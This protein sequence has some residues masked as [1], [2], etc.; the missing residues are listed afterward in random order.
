MYQELIEA[1][2]RG[3][4][5]AGRWERNERR[6]SICNGSRPR[7]LSTTAGDLEL[8]IPKL[9]SGSFFH[10]LLERRMRVDQAL[11]AVIMEAYLHGV[12]TRK[13]DD[14]VKALG[15]DTGISKSEV[16]RI[17]QA[18]DDEG[19]AFRDRSLTDSDY[20]YVF[21]DA[22][23]CKARVNHQIVSQ[24]IV[25]AIG[26]SAEGLHKHREVL[27]MDVGNSEDGTFLDCVSAGA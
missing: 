23:Y 15:V 17:A 18:L 20:P 9:R 6:S 5:G 26:V 10:G 14:L 16:S 25:I 27:G 21:L 2:A 3:V 22:P 13:V 4:I 8:R 1:E 12:S 19:A 24:A 11:F 7:T